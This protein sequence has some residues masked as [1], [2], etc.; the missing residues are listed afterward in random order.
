MIQ[1]HTFQCMVLLLSGL[2]HIFHLKI[3]P[4]A[5]SEHENTTKYLG[6]MPP[7]DPTERYIVIQQFSGWLSKSYSRMRLS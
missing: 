4:E 7:A 6:G 5:V 2:P 1:R 3:T